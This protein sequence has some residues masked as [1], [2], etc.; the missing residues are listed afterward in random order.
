MLREKA[1]EDTVKGTREAVAAEYREG[2]EAYFRVLAE[3]ARDR[4]SRL[5]YDRTPEDHETDLTPQ[6]FF[7]LRCTAC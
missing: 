5:R 2:V 6:R 1:A 4:T 7:R 3:K